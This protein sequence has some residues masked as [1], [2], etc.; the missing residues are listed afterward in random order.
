MKAETEAEI[1]CCLGVILGREEGNLSHSIRRLDS[2]RAEA[3]GHLRHYLG[4]RSYEKAW[5]L[6]EGGDPEK[7]ICS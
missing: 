7:G 2:L 6:L 5:I 3:G 1:R 4:K